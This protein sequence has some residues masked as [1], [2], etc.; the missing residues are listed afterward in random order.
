[1]DA[2]RI[3]YLIDTSVFIAIEQGRE[4]TAVP[5]D[6]PWHVSAITIGELK[7]GV[8]SQRRPEDASRRLDTW[9]EVTSA[10]DGLPVDD[11]VA[12]TWGEYR[13]IADAEGR[14]LKVADSLI[15]ATAATHGMILVTQDRGFEWYP[16]L[17]VLVV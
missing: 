5:E 1:V 13:A 14:R 8:L 6:G 10:F 4:L 3:G 11:T 7:A 15:A 17:D 16:D 2:E 9:I 12:N